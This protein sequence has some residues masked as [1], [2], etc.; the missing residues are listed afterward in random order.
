[1][2]ARITE[3]CSGDGNDELARCLHLSR[4]CC[5]EMEY[6]LLL[7]HD[8]KYIDPPTHEVLLAQLVEVRKMLSG[9]LRTVKS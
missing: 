9:L 3:G 2:T 1:M 8:L 5:Y 4:A 6:L 7:A